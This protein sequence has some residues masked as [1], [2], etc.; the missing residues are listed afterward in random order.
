MSFE[1]EEK[2]EQ[3]RNIVEPE[4]AESPLYQ[5]HVASTLATSRTSST[6]TSPNST[7]N[8]VHSN[9]QKL[10]PPYSVINMESSP[11]LTNPT[12]RKV[13]EAYDD[14]KDFSFDHDENKY[15]RKSAI[16]WFLRWWKLITRT[17]GHRRNNTGSLY[18]RYAIL[19]IIGIAL[20][21]MIVMLFSWLGRMAT[22]G[23]PS[24][25]P[26]NNPMININDNNDHEQLN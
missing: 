6:V 12:S 19:L 22:D 18:K 1:R 25:N 21:V 10:G 9:N 16:E 8:N 5:N 4:N 11:L 3:I 17:P 7:S 26:I 24:Y 14:P 23:D 15:Q 2:S 20:F 13:F